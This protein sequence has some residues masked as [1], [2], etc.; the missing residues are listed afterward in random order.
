M[1]ADQ[2]SIG[3]P[4]LL[5]QATQNTGHVSYVWH[6]FLLKFMAWRIHT[7]RCNSYWK[8]S[9][10]GAYQLRRNL[11]IAVCVTGKAV[12]RDMTISAHWGMKIITENVFLPLMN[13]GS[14]EM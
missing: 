2:S 10:R 9:L 12:P 1:H 6:G 4:A 11:I 14:L 3:T 13:E 5:G 7:S 8:M